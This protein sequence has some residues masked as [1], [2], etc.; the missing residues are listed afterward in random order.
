MSNISVAV[1]QCGLQ[2]CDSTMSVIYRGPD[3]EPPRPP[4]SS[5]R[6]KRGGDIATSH[7]SLSPSSP[8]VGTV[9]RAMF[10]QSGRARAVFVDSEP[11]VIA[12]LQAD[13]RRPWISSSGAGIA[14]ETSGNGNNWAQGY[15]QSS[16]L[17]KRTMELIRK[18]VESCDWYRG[19]ILYHALGGGTGSGT[20]T[21]IAS[22]LRDEYTKCG[23]VSACLAPSA[24]SES[25]VYGYNSMLSLW[26]L[27]QHSDSIIMFTN[28]DLHQRAS[29]AVVGNQETQNIM[30]D[31]IN[32]PLSEINTQCAL[33]ICGAIYPTTQPCGA[34]RGVSPFRST[35]IHDTISDV[36]PI[37]DMKY[38]DIRTS[39]FSLPSDRERARRRL[40]QTRSTD[41]WARTAKLLLKTI[42]KF[43]VENE[44]IL[45][46]NQKIIVRGYDDGT[47]SPWKVSGNKITKKII[48]TCNPVS[49]NLDAKL[50]P[51]RCVSRSTMDA[52]GGRSMTCVSNRTDAPALL[53]RLHNKTAEM[54][55]AS[56]YI[57]WFEEHGCDKDFFIEAFESVEKTVEAY[58]AASQT[59]ARG[60]LQNTVISTPHNRQTVILP[61]TPSTPSSLT[62]S[63]TAATTKMADPYD[64]LSKKT[65][66]GDVPL[67]HLL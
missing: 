30:T 64:V 21:R 2:I 48:Q 39:V 14:H 12:N 47:Q 11:R 67:N 27:Q 58:R 13:P 19:A 4:S 8:P 54:Y 7:Q 60:V 17:V 63:V 22:N 46:L 5:K 38:V 56:A 40:K 57:H 45:T 20:G 15:L 33:A 37:A 10:H 1:G 34:S 61:N 16:K 42:P 66:K 28:D 26:Q 35:T 6:S 31:Q 29:R 25:P 55:S 49:W 32:I 9:Q 44:H 24:T 18:E 50:N 52:F 43:N 3:Y 62:S 53:R 36:T 65:G 41:S 23:I 51:L 59:E